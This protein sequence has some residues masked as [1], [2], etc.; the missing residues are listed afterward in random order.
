MM[1]AQMTGD[2]TPRKH[3]QMLEPAKKF[4]AEQHVL[5]NQESRLDA[6]ARRAP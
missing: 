1:P 5:L 6:A 2:G 4:F 3:R